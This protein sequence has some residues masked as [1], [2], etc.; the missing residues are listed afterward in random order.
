MLTQWEQELKILENWLDNL[1]T[2]KYC[3]REA[4]M[5]VKKEFQPKEKLD[6]YGLV[7]SQ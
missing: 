2:E 3:H 1:E 4:V 7:P 6:E 5:Q